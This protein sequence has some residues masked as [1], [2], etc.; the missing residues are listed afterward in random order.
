MKLSY[1]LTLTDFKAA[2]N[3]HRRQRFHDK[4]CILF[5]QFSWL[6]VSSERSFRVETL[7]LSFSRSALRWDQDYSS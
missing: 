3:L 6:Y 5:G 4:S 2:R 1:T 7:I